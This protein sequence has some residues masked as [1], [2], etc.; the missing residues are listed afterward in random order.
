MDATGTA[1][2][3]AG[4]GAEAAPGFDGLYEA[5]DAMLTGGDW[6]GLAA[7][8]GAGVLGYF[9]WRKKKRAAQASDASR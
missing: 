6:T 7:V 3:G 4:A 1:A 9:V 5:I 8:L 2:A